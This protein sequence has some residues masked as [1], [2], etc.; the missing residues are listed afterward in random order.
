MAAKRM[1]DRSFY[2]GICGVKWHIES[3]AKTL[4]E[5]YNDL[6]L[7][8]KEKAES[9][10]VDESGDFLYKPLYMQTRFR[11]VC[12]TCFFAIAELVESRKDLINKKG[13]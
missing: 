13:A 1:I 7:P 8:S 12:P 3:D 2:C 4:D 5:E 10:E 6:T 9:T 11:T